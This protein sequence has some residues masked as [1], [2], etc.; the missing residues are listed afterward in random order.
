MKRGPLQFLVSFLYRIALS[1]SATV[2]FQNSDDRDL[3]VGRKLVG[4]GR[5]GLVRGSGIDLDH[6][7]PRPHRAEDGTTSFLLVARILR[8]KGVVEYVEA[9]RILRGEGLA[10]RFAILGP[11]GVD[12]RTAISAEEL[13][14][15]LA[16]GVVEL[17]GSADD[18]RPYVAD[19]DCIV[20][21]SYREG[22]PRSLIEAAAMGRPVIT[23]DVPGCREVVDPGE[24]GLLCEVRSA[25][26]LADAMRRFADL[27]T[28]ERLAMGERG[29][30]KAV[31]EFGQARICAA[32]ARALD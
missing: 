14:V 19:A 28:A 5:A 31:A 13:G 6:F 9:A 23:T 20:L 11:A 26:S 25:A 18:V 2:F 22:L 8:D 1:R 4:K 16:E 12:N 21:P 24:T 30:D 7:A 17:F 3:F 29:R 27:P 15:W 10:M 32:Y